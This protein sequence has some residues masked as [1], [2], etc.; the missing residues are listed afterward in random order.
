M[1]KFRARIVFFYVILVETINLSYTNDY[2]IAQAHDL[3]T[4][5]AVTDLVDFH[6]SISILLDKL[7]WRLQIVFPRSPQP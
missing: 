7:R 6:D 3:T 4:L 5:H 1:D 2:R